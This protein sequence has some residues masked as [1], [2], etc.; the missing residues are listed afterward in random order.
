MMM[1]GPTHD[2]GAV[3]C[4]KRVERAISVARH[5]MEKTQHRS[6]SIPDAQPPRERYD[7]AEHTQEE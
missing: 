5:V 1:W 7:G 2:V 3:G 6:W 4:L